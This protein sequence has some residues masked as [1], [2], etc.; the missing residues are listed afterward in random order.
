M[1]FHKNCADRGRG[2]TNRELLER[3]GCTIWYDEAN[4]LGAVEKRLGEKIPELGQGYSLPENLRRTGSGGEASV[5]YGSEVGKGGGISAEDRAR[6]EAHVQ[7][8]KPAV[9]EL[10]G[11]E[12]EAQN[13]WLGMMQGC[14]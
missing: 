4:L 12:I 7:S 9:R 1:W 14:F 3:G 13:I 10:A 2:C 8:L 6:I 11:L 5:E